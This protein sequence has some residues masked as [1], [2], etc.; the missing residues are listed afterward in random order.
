MITKEQCEHDIQEAG[1]VCSSCGGQLSAIDTVDNSDNPTHWPGCT[2]CNRFDHGV[3]STIFNIADEMVRKQGYIHYSHMGQSYG[4][5]GEELR[6]WYISQ[7]SGAS[8][9]VSLIIMLYKTKQSCPT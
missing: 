2:S 1:R 6:Q 3:E 9:L 4:K 7:I 5:T 8:G